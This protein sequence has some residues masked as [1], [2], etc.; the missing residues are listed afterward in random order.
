MA[1]PGNA[2]VLKHAFVH[3]NRFPKGFP[4][5]NPGGGVHMAEL[6]QLQNGNFSLE[7][8]LSQE[9]ND[10]IIA[11]NNGKPLSSI[12]ENSLYYIDFVYDL[13]NKDYSL[14]IIDESSVRN[15]DKEM[16]YSNLLQNN[17]ENIV[18]EMKLRFELCPTTISNV[19]KIKKSAS[20]P[21]YSEIIRRALMI[22]YSTKKIIRNNYKVCFLNK[23]ATELICIY[24]EDIELYAMRFY[25]KK[26]KEG[27]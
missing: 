22:W 25:A 6:Q 23:E 4:G 10:E 5:S 11:L 12:A 17:L 18:S 15:K 9:E 1:Q 16:Q 26:D 8:R 13:L 14:K 7:V 20:A 27:E 24:E 2:T 3:P 19:N 21:S